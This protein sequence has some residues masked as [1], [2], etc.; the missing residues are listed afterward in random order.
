[1]STAALDNVLPNALIYGTGVFR[2]SASISVEDAVY[3]VYVQCTQSKDLLVALFNR[4]HNKEFEATLCG[5]IN[6]QFVM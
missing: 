1:M 6:V 3:G 4:A 2:T 5:N